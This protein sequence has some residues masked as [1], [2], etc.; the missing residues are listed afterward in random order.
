MC[1]VGLIN[2]WTLL[3]P[4]RSAANSGV[5]GEQYVIQERREIDVLI[6]EE[7]SALAS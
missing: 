4:H 1:L 6:Q 7:A 2:S 5:R 3:T